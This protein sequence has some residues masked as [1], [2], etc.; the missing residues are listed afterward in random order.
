MKQEKIKQIYE[1]RLFLKKTTLKEDN[2]QLWYIMNNLS[3]D[4]NIT[5]LDAGCG[6][7]N[8][9]YYFATLGYKNIYAV[10]LF[11]KIDSDKFIYTQ[12]SIDKLPFSDDFFDFIYSNSV[13]YYLENPEN[14]IKE[15][16]R[17]IKK[18]GIIVFTAHT[19]YSIF[20]LW[21]II[22]RDI[23]K[24][25]SMEYLIEAK[26]YSANYYK[27]ILKKNGFEIILQDGYNISFFLY[28]LYIKITKVIDKLFNIKLPILEPYLNNNII[29]KIKS[30]ISYHSVFIIRKIDD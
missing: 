7:G 18:K 15:F 30:E 24:L 11:S 10:D 29:G 13:I 19:K 8:Y 28:P 27:K 17:I 21:R 25:D 20:T 26:F 1:K 2:I 4:K 5:L 3:K 16:K 23:L 6:S 12:A 9:A 14:A 22:K